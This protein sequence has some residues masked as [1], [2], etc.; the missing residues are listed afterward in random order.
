LI[1]RPSCLSALAL[2]NLT[3]MKSQGDKV[4]EVIH[5]QVPLRI[6][7]VDL[8]RLAELGFERFSNALIPTQ[9]GWLDGQ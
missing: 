6:P 8:A 3:K 4:K 5:P 7:C 9:L 1:Y 2:I